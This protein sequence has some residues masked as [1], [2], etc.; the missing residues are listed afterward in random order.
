[1]TE[2]AGPIGSGIDSLMDQYQAVSHNISNASTAGFKRRITTFSSELDRLLGGTGNKESFSAQVESRQ[3]VDFSQGALVATE[4]SLDIALDGKGFLALETPSGPLYTR[5]GAM[6]VNMLGQ[7]VDGADR[8]VAGENGPIVI[9]N[10][11]GL[12]EI[13]I[14]PDGTVRGGDAELGRLKIVEFDGTENQLI[15]GNYSSFIAPDGVVPSAAKNTT[16]RQGYQEGSNVRPMEEMVSLMTLSR[17]YET[18]MNILR[19]QRENT[20]ATLGVANG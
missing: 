7:L 14:G 16:V 10:N 3:T 12:S 6:Q 13:N 9:P 4:R 1:M 17:L 2:S 15:C 19:R 5:N 18:N 20:N 8:I 11:V